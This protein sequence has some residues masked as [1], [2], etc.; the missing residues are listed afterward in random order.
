MS[1]GATKTFAGSIPLNFEQQKINGEFVEI[2]GEKYYKISN[3]DQMRPFFMSITSDAD[4]W[5][6]ASSN[7]GIS[8]GRKNS[9]HAVFPYYTDDKLTDLNQNTGSKSAFVVGLDDKWQLW[10]PFS[11]TYKGIYHISRNLYKN[12]Y[13]NKLIFEETN[14]DLGLTF[15]YSWL[16]SRNYGIIKKSELVNLTNDE[17][18]INLL[19]GIENILPFGIG[20]YVQLSKSNLANAYKKSELRSESRIG[21]YCL[22]SNIIDRPEPSEALLATTVCFSGL[23]EVS[24]LLCN[25]QISLFLQGEEVMEEKEIRAE[26]GA[27]LITNK[28]LLRSNESKEWYFA[29]DTS[30]SATDVSI[31]EEL[32]LKNV[33]FTE[34]LENDIEKSTDR[35]KQLI[36]HADGFQLSNDTAGNVRHISN[37][38]FNIMRGGIFADSYEIESEDFIEFVKKRNQLVLN[39]NIDFLK[40]FPEKFHVNE[41][42]ERLLENGDADLLRYGYEYLPITFSRRHGDPSRPWNKFNIDV[43]GKKDAWKKSFEG[44]WRD[45]FQNWEALGFAYPEFAENMIALFLNASTVDGYNPYRITNNGIEWEIIDPGDPWSFIGYW[46]DHQIIYLLKLLELSNAFHPDRL[47]E[48]IN[49]PFFTFGNVPYRIKNYKEMVQNPHETISYDEEEEKIIA[50]RVKQV[51]IDGKLLR[52]QHDTIAK[53]T[54]TE[55]LLIPLLSKISN[56]VPEGGIWMN[57]QRPE[58][59]DA[60]NALVGQGLSMVTVY[61]MYR[62]ICFI[63][64]FYQ[65]LDVKEFEVNNE[66]KKFFDSV[67]N[68]LKENQSLLNGEISNEHRKNITDLLGHVGENYRKQVYGL[69]NESKSIIGKAELLSFMDVS[70]SFLEHTIKANKRTDNLYHAYN[71]IEINTNE[72][73]IKHLY[74]MLE[75]QVALLSSGLVNA[76]EALEILNALRKSEL[77]REDQNSYILY[78]DRSLSKFMDKAVADKTLIDRSELLKKL[79]K[80]GDSSILIKGKEGNYHF[81]PNLSNANA[82]KTTLDNLRVKGYDELIEQEQ[83]LI[84]DAY[85]SVFNHHSFTGRSGTFF[86]YEGLGSIYW[87]MNSKLLLAVQEILQHTLEEDEDQ[88]VMDGLKK[89]YAEIKDGL[90]THKSPEQYGAF[91]ID[92]YSHTPAHK[93]A[94]QPG[95]TGQVKED[96]LSKIGEL[97]VRIIEGKITFS[98]LLLSPTEFITDKNDLSDF[99]ISGL[100]LDNYLAFTICSTPIVYRNSSKREHITVFY[101]DGSPTA[102]E[103]LVLGKEESVKIFN[104]DKSIAYVQVYIQP[105]LT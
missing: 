101:K 104:R 17:K 38:L 93:G 19:D 97:G 60:N 70:A 30:K 31:L 52:T 98:G 54:L 2:H 24:H 34:V 95:M 49:K 56:F 66:I 22:S 73:G 92:P 87:H 82:L 63:R 79:I 5:L 20:E 76:K 62:Y 21:I 39:H 83:E 6:F 3:Y 44:N 23:N 55:K 68:V 36:A 90:G 77:Y 45:I 51:G 89:H 14:L 99:G 61:Y 26:P 48:F 43:L 59:N 81:N 103:N 41:L 50:D 33:G 28:L 12:S 8:A 29:I 10:L 16:N 57:T 18:K 71:L 84:F 100:V 69:Y 9:D 65:R 13:G 40:L 85:E 75:G 94:Q 7:G 4:I 86:G 72:F 78:P 80:A 64:D 27:Y 1:D 91:P 88:H 58:W 32:I 35:L 46:G 25:R 11:D 53:A 102:F 74:P 37:T 15:R 105:K 42:R 47:Q 67:T 96:I